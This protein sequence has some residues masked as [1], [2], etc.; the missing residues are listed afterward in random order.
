MNKTTYIPCFKKKYS[1]DDFGTIQIRI[2]TNRKSKYET[3]GEKIKEKY[4]MGN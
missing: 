2:T 4:L 3:L 1:T